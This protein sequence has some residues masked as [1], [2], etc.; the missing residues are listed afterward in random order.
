MKSEWVIIRYLTG[1]FVKSEYV[2]S[3]SDFELSKYGDDVFVA[4]LEPFS[5]NLI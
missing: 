1:Y 2:V 3:L 4:D 5:S